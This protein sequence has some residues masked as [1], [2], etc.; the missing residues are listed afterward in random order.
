M[1]IP[2]L[3]LSVGRSHDKHGNTYGLLRAYRGHGG[4]LRSTIF[5]LGT[6][7]YGDAAGLPRN[8]GSHRNAP[9]CLPP[10]AEVGD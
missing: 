5:R 9:Q 3:A 10:L 8:P 6:Q 7:R 2:F 1:F 4:P